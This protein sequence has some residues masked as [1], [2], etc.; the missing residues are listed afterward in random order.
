M[1]KN[2]DRP[3]TLFKAPL[4]TIFIFFKVTFQAIWKYTFQNLKI[5]VSIFFLSAIYY[6]LHF[7][8]ISGILKNLS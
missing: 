3:P 7:H 2:Q 8:T 1:N 4:L 5:F 6:A